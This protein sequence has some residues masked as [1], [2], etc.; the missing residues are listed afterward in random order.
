MGFS[1]S[2]SSGSVQEATLS[3]QKTPVVLLKLRTQ[4]RKGPWEGI[5]NVKTGEESVPPKVP[6]KRPLRKT[7]GALGME[8]GASELCT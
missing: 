3:V 8:M 5:G 2:G 4:G 6:W 7:K 1:A